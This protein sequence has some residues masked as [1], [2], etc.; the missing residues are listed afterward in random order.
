MY[1]DKHWL[2]HT[3][4]IH[5][6]DTVL[7]KQLHKTNKLTPYF[8]PVSSQ[9]IRKDGNAVILQSPG[10]LLHMRNSTHVNQFIPTAVTTLV[11]DIICDVTEA[12]QPTL[13][14]PTRLDPQETA[15]TTFSP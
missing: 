2:A 15:P 13:C 11:A 5:A 1:A 6:G 4:D 12:V 3:R 7:V 9:V 10:G 14:T 8:E